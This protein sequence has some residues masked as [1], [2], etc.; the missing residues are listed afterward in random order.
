MD[1][2][3]RQGGGKD[4]TCAV[5]FARARVGP[6]GAQARSL[7][8]RGA[9][10]AGT[11]PNSRHL[12]SISRAAVVPLS[13]P[14]G[15]QPTDSAKCVASRAGRL[16]RC[17]RRVS[18]S[19]SLSL[20]LRLLP[21]SPLSLFCFLALSIAAPSL[22]PPAPFSP[23]PAIA[24]VRPA[25]VAARS[26]KSKAQVFFFDGSVSGAKKADLTKQIKV[27]KKVWDTSDYLDNTV[28]YVVTCRKDFQKYNTRSKATGSSPPFDHSPP[29]HSIEPSPNNEDTARSESFG[30]AAAVCV[31]VF[32]CLC[33]CV[34]VRERK[35]CRILRRV[36]GAFRGQRGERG[37][38]SLVG[39][40]RAVNKGLASTTSA[41]PE[42]A[43]WGDAFRRCRCRRGV[44]SASSAPRPPTKLAAAAAR[45]R[46]GESSAA[47]APCR[48]LP[49]RRK[50]R[51]VLTPAV[52][53]CPLCT[54]AAHRSMPEA[55]SSPEQPP[56]EQ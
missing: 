19:R 39:P 1:R 31:C 12:A 23:S 15:R 44:A 24:S 30:R 8:A 7:C 29:V 10:A 38:A 46:T 3:V 40:R 14:L 37:H 4:P 17:V 53:R 55:P 25:P 52:R 47:G 51:S 54:C 27:S 16:T 56:R 18:L 49:T 41:L 34:C 2:P 32:V 50:G 36:V 9:C 42:R 22:A 48:R 20:F 45:R 35:G 21:P 26:R 13:A 28:T 33:V 11:K 5:A 43:S 6:W